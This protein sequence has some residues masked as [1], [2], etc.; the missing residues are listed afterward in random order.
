LTRIIQIVK[1]LSGFGEGHDRTNRAKKNIA[2]SFFIKGANIAVGLIL[3]PITIN[4]LTPTKYGIWITMTSIVAWFGFFDVGLGNGL[5]NRFAEAIAKGNHALAKIYVS[6]TYAILI[7]IISVF[8]LLFYIINI[9]LNWSIILNTGDDPLLR[10]ELSYLAIVVFTSFGMTFV[11]NLISIILSADQRSAKSGVF[12]LLGKSLSLLF[13]YILTRLSTSSLLSLGLIYCT[14]TPFVLAISTIWFF[15]KKYR[16]YRPSLRSVDFSK[17]KDLF[18]LGIKFF[19]IQISAI[20]LYQTNTMIITQLFG[21]AMVTPYSVAYK[22]FSVL[23]MGF[24]IIVTPF[25]SAFTEAWTKQ[26]LSWIK[27]IMK[28]LIRLW[29][30]LFSIGMIMLLFSGFIFKVWIGHNFSVPIAISVLSLSWILINAWNGIFSQFLNGVGKIKI[31]LII[32]VGAAIINIPMAI[33]LGKLM[34]IAGILLSNS[35]LGLVTV[36]IYPIQYK[37]LIHGTAHGLFNS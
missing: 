35:I 15:N 17:A 12:D 2:A 18:N 21:P 33:F 26:D 1:N 32:G 3:V 14:I 25:W 28:K 20:V 36:F 30:V 13:I 5:K 24:M 31:Q 7:I 29:L 23:I 8:L 9:F 6:T 34:G 4:Y 10:K 19:V 37:K 27:R 11:L 22:Y 16:P